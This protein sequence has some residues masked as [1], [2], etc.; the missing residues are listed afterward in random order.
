[1]G[2]GFDTQFDYYDATNP[3]RDPN[4]PNVAIATV[5]N[6]TTFSQ[7]I[8]GQVF[9]MSANAPATGNITITQNFGGQNYTFTIARN[10]GTI[11]G[12]TAVGPWIGP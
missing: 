3:S 6:V 5:G 1:M 9:T 4:N 2:S 11:V 7:T 8:D 12:I 10:G